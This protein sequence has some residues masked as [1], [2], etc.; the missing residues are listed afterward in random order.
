MIEAAAPTDADDPPPSP[1]VVGPILRLLVGLALV[2][3][4]L[5]LAWQ[6]WDVLAAGNP[7][8]VAVAVVL[9]ILGLLTVGLALAR[10]RGRRVKRS[11]LRSAVVGLGLVVALLI[12]GFLG[13]ARPLPAEPAAVAALSSSE[14][15]GYRSHAGWY[16]FVPATVPRVGFVFY[17]GAKVDARAY[18]AMLRPLAES[19][20][21]VAVVAE[22]A[23]IALIPG[24]PVRTA[25]DAHPEIEAWAVGGHSLGGVAAAL[26]A[27]GDVGIDAVVFWGSFPAGEM[28]AD[29]EVLSVSGTQDGLST[30]DTVEA[31]RG[32]LPPNAQYAVVEGANH[33]AF[34]DYG[35][36]SGDNPAVGDPAAL[37]SEITDET[38][39]FL[40]GLNPP[41]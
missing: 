35:P 39:N 37:R 29:L 18:A 28:R 34:G 17:P 4:P 11:R 32:D 5:T 2:A 15:V 24:T 12:S 10:L 7:I 21:L 23:G 20:I 41:S 1:S 27:E 31:S 16:E 40:A 38:Y 6:R 13:W 14:G 36:Q 25:I 8:T 19:G 30:P 26:Q 33:A 3:G 9:V 22:P